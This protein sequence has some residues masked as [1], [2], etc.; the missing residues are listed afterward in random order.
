MNRHDQLKY[1]RFL[2]RSGCLVAL[3]SMIAGFLL[4]AFLAMRDAFF[5]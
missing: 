3:G 2:L 4:I 5:S 1:A